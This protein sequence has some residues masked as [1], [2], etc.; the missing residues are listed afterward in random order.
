MA[1]ELILNLL[2]GAGIGLFQFFILPKGTLKTWRWIPTN[3]LAV[4][5][6]VVSSLLSVPF[7]H[8]ANSPFLRFEVLP[9]VQGAIYGCLTCI[10][11]E[12]ILGRKDAAEVEG[13]AR[14]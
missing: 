13:A 11:L 7:L 6:V 2:Q 5:A 10:P 12:S 1:S 9:F 4:V 14:P 8:A 3:A